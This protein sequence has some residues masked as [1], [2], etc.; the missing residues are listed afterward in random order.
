MTTSDKIIAEERD[1]LIIQK[2]LILK[3]RQLEERVKEQRAEFQSEKKQWNRIQRTFFDYVFQNLDIDRAR[4]IGQLLDKRL[5]EWFGKDGEDEEDEQV[6]LDMVDM[7]YLLY[8]EDL[9]EESK[10]NKP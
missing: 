9:E 8:L 10:V 4:K 1:E 3:V 6:F 2:A 7:Y 5:I